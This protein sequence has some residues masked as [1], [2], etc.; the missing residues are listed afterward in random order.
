MIVRIDT[1]NLSRG[2]EF[3]LFA[4][5]PAGKPVKMRYL[6]IPSGDIGEIEFSHR[7][8]GTLDAYDAVA[9]VIDGYLMATIG[10]QKVAKKIGNPITSFVI[11]YRQGYTL[12][13][14]AI[15]HDGDEIETG[16]LRDAGL[17]WY[18]AVLPPETAVLETA[19]KK[20]IIN[21]DL[22]KME[23]EVTMDG[24]SLG[25][26]YLPSS[27]D[28]MALPELTLPDVGLNDAELDSTLPDVTIKEL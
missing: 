28:E 4:T 11:G 9:P 15:S 16:E 14:T 23:Y 18:W 22:L 13:Y 7:V 19:G 12:P 17:G 3:S 20:F 21:K 2:R 5:N 8:A 10:K 24:G 26:S 6:S 27:I 1:T 25:S